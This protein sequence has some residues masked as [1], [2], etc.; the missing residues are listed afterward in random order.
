MPTLMLTLPHQLE[1][2]RE[3]AAINPVLKLHSSKKTIPS[4]TGHRVLSSFDTTA[5]KSCG[6][7]LKSASRR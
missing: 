2:S 4:P 1:Q 5:S 3:A 6:S 7:F